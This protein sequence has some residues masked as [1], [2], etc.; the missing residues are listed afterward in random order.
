MSAGL[1]IYN[2]RGGVVLDS[3]EPQY[4]FVAKVNMEM[5]TP[6]PTTPHWK[7]YRADITEYFKDSCIIVVEYPEGQAGSYAITQSGGR[8]YVSSMFGLNPNTLKIITPPP[9]CYIF[10]DAPPPPAVSNFGM[11]ITGEFG[12][13][14][15]NT[16]YPLLKVIDFREITTQASAQWYP[17]WTYVGP[18]AGQLLAVETSA[19]QTGAGYTPE[20]Y[21]IEGWSI[22]TKNEGGSFFIRTSEY[23]QTMGE[24][25]VERTIS[26]RVRIILIQKP[27]T[28]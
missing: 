22:E 8:Y 21:T 11:E 1:I 10:S 27:L 24:A 25:E 13:A 9:V 12:E 7:S 18:S 2:D 28:V 4:R 26:M 5:F 6:Y 17:V 3:T 16:D 19:G 15:L 20:G 23:Q 14:V